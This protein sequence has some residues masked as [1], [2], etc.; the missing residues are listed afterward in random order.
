M[1]TSQTKST[2]SLQSS[3][4]LL[5]K[6]DLMQNLPS[7][8]WQELA[9]VIRT[10]ACPGLRILTID[11]VI[12]ALSFFSIGFSLFCAP[13]IRNSASFSGPEEVAWHLGSPETGLAGYILSM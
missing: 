13:Q 5:H 11:L 8:L 4:S 3:C 10:I 7:R 6:W 9:I 12:W 1:P 2:I